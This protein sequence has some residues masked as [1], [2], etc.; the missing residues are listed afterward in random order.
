MIFETE[1]NSIELLRRSNQ[2]YTSYR[3]RYGDTYTGDQG[4]TAS[5]HLSKDTRN[6][7]INPPQ[8]AYKLS[9]LESS[10]EGF[11]YLRSNISNSWLPA[12]CILHWTC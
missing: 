8:P 4:V 2:F 9:S 6:L 5:L 11:P 10:E 7:L 3:V 12:L 1:I